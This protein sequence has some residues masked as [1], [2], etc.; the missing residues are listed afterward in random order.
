ME[1]EMK[2]TYHLNPSDKIDD[3][4]RKIERIRTF[5]DIIQ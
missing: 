5:M 3:L 1:E 2:A 4:T